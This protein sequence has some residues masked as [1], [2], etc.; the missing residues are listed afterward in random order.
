MLVSKGV[1]LQPKAFAMGVRA[2]HRQQ[3]IDERQYG[4]YAGHPELGAATYK[5]TAQ[6]GGRGVYSFCMCPGGEVVCSATEPGGT[7]V[8][9]MSY[10][11]R[12]LQKPTAR[13][14]SRFSR[15][16]CRAGPLGGVQMQRQIEQAAYRAAKGYGAVAQR[17]ADFVR[18]MPSRSA[19]AIASS[20]R[21]YT[22]GGE[23]RDFRRLSGGR[24]GRGGAAV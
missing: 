6:H 23:I 14:L 7:A 16:I 18:G 9:G 22:V 19:G 1:A 8:N 21:P 10:Y 4:K 2:E 15:R 24:P 11:A 5:L 13:W 20:Y 17:Y 3:F 12:D